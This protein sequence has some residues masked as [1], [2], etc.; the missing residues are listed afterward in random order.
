LTGV[1]ARDVVGEED[2]VA[3]EGAGATEVGDVAG[4]AAE[5]GGGERGLAKGGTVLGWSGKRARA[6]VGEGTEFGSGE[7]DCAGEEALEPL[8][9]GE[10][11]IA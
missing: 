7:V 10:F 5:V 2:V 4:G 6:G 8:Q 11:P 9:V 1:E 3:W